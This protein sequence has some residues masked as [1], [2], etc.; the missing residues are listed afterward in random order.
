MG[1][2]AQYTQKVEKRE[3]VLSSGSS[4]R[5]INFASCLSH[6]SQSNKQKLIMQQTANSISSPFKQ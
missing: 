1:N 5:S 4:Q 3:H 2:Q 6:R